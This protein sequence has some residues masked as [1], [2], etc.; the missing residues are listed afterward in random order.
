MDKDALII[1]KPK[2]GEAKMQIVCMRYLDING[3]P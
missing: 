1:I 2:A 3:S